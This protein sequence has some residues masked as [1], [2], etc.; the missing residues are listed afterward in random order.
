MVVM[1]VVVAVGMVVRAAV[2]QGGV[3]VVTMGHETTSIAR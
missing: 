2:P 3:L 1:G